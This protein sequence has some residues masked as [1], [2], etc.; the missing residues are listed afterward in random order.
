[1]IGLPIEL[2]VETMR[3]LHVDA[4]SG[5]PSFVSGLSVIR[6]VPVPVVDVGRLLGEECRHPQR[7]VTVRAGH[8]TVALAVG[9]VIGLR[10]VAV[11]ELQTLPPLLRNAPAAIVPCLGTLDGELLLVLQSAHVVPEDVWD[12]AA[13]TVAL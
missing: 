13:A 12:R 4:L 7:F 8:R 11:G 1:L 2:V 6:G 3:P 10:P 9:D 5:A